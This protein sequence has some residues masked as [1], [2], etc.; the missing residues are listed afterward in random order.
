[1]SPFYKDVIFTVDIRS[2]GF[3]I[4]ND[5]YSVSGFF[6]I[7][8]LLIIPIAPLLFFILNYCLVPLKMEYIYMLTFGIYLI[9]S[10]A[11]IL[12]FF[13]LITQVIKNKKVG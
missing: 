4:K 12:T 13:E 6:P 2:I 9:P 10:S 7:L 8:N 3:E 11:D 1:M 5:E